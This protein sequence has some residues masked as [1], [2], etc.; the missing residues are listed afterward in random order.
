MLEKKK[1]WADLMD[2]WNA[3]A[4]QITW[5]FNESQLSGVW[6]PSTSGDQMWSVLSNLPIDC[7][8][9]KNPVRLEA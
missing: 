9:K 8:K 2:V 4:N 5:H 7:L 6:L 1:A 3:D